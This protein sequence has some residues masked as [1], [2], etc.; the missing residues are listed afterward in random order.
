[1][2]EFYHLY[3]SDETFA[4]EIRNTSNQGKIKE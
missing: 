1:M 3:L 2:Q 4:S